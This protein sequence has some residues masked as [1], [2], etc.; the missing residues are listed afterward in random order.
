MKN[1]ILSALE[2][3]GVEN[4]IIHTKRVE[5][6]ELFLI[7]KRR[8][9]AREKDV[10]SARVTVFR[11]FEADGVK[12]RGSAEAILFDGMTADEI[13]S[14]IASAWYAAQFV[15]NPFFELAAP[16]K[17]F[18]D[19]DILSL[20]DSAEKLAEALSR[21]DAAA[22]AFINSAEV[23]AERHTINIITSNGGEVGYVKYS[24]NGEMVAQC[25]FPEDVELFREFRYDKP[26]VEALE[27]EAEALIAAARDRARAKQ[28]P[29]AGEYDV[30]ISGRELATLMSNY[31]DK[32]EAGMIYAKYSNYAIGK[33][34]QG[35][36]VRGEKLDMRYI[37]REPYNPEGV[38]MSDTDMTIGG[39]LQNVHGNTRFCRYLGVEP[40][41][42][43]DKIEVK[44][45]TKPLAD[46]KRGR[47]LHPVAFSDF[48]MD[49]LTGR[50]GGEIR[51]AYL[52][53][54]ETIAAVTGGSINGSLL[55]KQGDLV[56][57]TERY[58]NSSYSGPF[59]ALIK[60]VSVAG[61]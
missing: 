48:Q 45:A 58:E 1:K 4:Y 12:M 46:M 40:T 21:S 51:L 6:R 41:G 49:F 20:K 25:A 34:V 56:F 42:L 47:Y 15:N 8:D 30:L 23:F 57:S 59:A 2:K 17:G 9:M 61:A 44:N 3:S 19:A 52:C 35:D 7:R 38:P 5:S 32:S 50:F 33:S 43:Y 16:S 31:L 53:D 14:E 10:T 24:F 60:G 26:D 39:I 36:D 22:D 29:L 18:K 55:E 13:S 11:D 54:G 37:A 27:K 28:A